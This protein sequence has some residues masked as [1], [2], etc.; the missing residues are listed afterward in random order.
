M[1]HVTR[2]L[3]RRLGSMVPIHKSLLCNFKRDPK[4]CVRH[5]SF[6]DASWDVAS[7]H[8][9]ERCLSARILMSL[10]EI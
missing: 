1:S 10:I 2:E 9:C 5:H 7:G 6:D 8:E 3:I 4:L